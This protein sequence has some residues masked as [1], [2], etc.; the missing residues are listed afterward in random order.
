MQ[1]C[2]IEMK[3]NCIDFDVTVALIM[4]NNSLNT[5]LE[6]WQFLQ[7]LTQLL[8]FSLLGTWRTTAWSKVNVLFIQHGVTHRRMYGPFVYWSVYVPAKQ[9]KLSFVLDRN[10]SGFVKCCSTKI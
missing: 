7:S 6:T 3:P 5:T 8:V 1:S 9:F 4:S 10:D 2:E